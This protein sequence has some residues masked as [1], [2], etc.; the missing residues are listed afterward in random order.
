MLYMSK[1]TSETTLSFNT[2]LDVKMRLQKMARE[3]GVT[4]SDLMRMSA[5]HLLNKGLR[6]DPSIEPS[7]YL[8]NSL[9]EADEDM[10]RGETTVVVG[11]EKPADYL[12][13][14]RK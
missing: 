7:E 10:K 9:K 2:P 14:S 12:G 13:N 3:N 6:I 8:L 1:A 5:M 11:E 4:I